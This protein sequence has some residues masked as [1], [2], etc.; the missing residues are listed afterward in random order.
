MNKS[1]ESAE[2]RRITREAIAGQ[3]FMGTFATDVDYF[4]T[5]GSVCNKLIRNRFVCLFALFTRLNSYWLKNPLKIHSRHRILKWADR[6]DLTAYEQRRQARFRI[7]KL[8]E[9]PYA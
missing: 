6:S 7:K 9:S 8:K 4:C 1:K 5:F 2:I 3:L